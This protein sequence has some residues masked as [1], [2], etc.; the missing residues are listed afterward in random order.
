[1]YVCMYVCM[2]IRIVHSAG[3]VQWKHYLNKTMDNTM[4]SSEQ[5]LRELRLFYVF[6]HS[7]YGH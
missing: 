3:R 7:V 5:M 6:L 4:E 1:M 2:Y